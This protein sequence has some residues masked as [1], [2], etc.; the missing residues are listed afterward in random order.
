MQGKV[1]KIGNRLN[2]AKLIKI[3]EINKKEKMKKVAV[4]FAAAFASFFIIASFAMTYA[5]E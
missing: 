5:I 2:L 1:E 3:P 4:Y